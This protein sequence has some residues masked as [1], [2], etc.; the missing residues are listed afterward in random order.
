MENLD[1]WHFDKRIPIVLVFAIL[2]QTF[3][4]VWFGA[5]L[6]NRVS[7]V[8]DTQRN[9]TQL[10]EGIRNSQSVRGER[11]AVLEEALRGLNKTLNEMNGK[12]DKVLQR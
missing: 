8:E 12:L 5:Q 6:S 7:N 10:I 9:Q 2:F 1:H 4:V 11:V 3:G